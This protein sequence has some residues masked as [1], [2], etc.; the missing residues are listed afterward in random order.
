MD[1]TGRPSVLLLEDDPQLGPLI[2]ELLADDV[3]VSLAADGEEG[4]RRALTGTW[5]ALVV[6]RGLPTR[7]GIEVIAAVRAA[8]IATPILILTALGAVDDR[9]EGLDAGADDYL[10]KPFDARELAARLRALTRTY[11]AQP[12]ERTFGA[13]SFQPGT[14]LAVSDYGERVSLSP[15]ECALLEVLVDAPGR[16]FTRAELID[17]VFSPDDQPGIVDTYVH[18]LRRKLGRSNI[19][20]V[21]GT[22]YQLGDGT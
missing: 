14:R 4:L 7:N 1:A 22:G 3:V 2:V 17:A 19:R 20:T 6:D 18:Y 16:V 5:D 8:G 10:V 12:A 15:R 9:V 21:H 13:W 11:A